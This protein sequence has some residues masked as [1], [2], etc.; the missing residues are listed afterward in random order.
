MIA[1]GIATRSVAA[2]LMA[3]ALFGVTILKVFLV[4]LAHLETIYRVVSFIGLGVILIAVS[5]AYTRFRTRI[6]DFV[7]SKE[8]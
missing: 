2:R 4:D 8:D 3:L 1:V 5:L 7:L 6:N